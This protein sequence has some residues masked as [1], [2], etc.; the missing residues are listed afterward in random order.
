M[1][2]NNQYRNKFIQTPFI[3]KMFQNTVLYKELMACTFSQFTRHWQMRKR[4][5]NKC[6]FSTVQHIIHLE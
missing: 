5:K 4:N 3:K 6:F 2:Y 1:F